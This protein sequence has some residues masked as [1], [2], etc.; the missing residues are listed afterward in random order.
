LR[1]SSASGS[2]RATRH[3][4]GDFPGGEV[5]LKYTFTLDHDLISKLVIEP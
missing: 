4:Q 5:D 1:S 3:L 2:T